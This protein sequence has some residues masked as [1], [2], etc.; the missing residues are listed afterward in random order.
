MAKKSYQRQSLFNQAI[1]GYRERHPEMNL[2]AVEQALAEFIHVS[3]ASVQKWRAGY[4]IREEYVPLI[5]NWAINH[6]G[7]S[8]AW[9]R[10]FL[11]S[12][13]YSD[14]DVEAVL[15]SESVIYSLVETCYQ[16]H[17]RL[18]GE[19]R[20]QAA[21][22]H[23]P[24]EGLLTLL[25]NFLTSEKP[26]LI[27]VAPSGMGKTD[28]ALW[29][30]HEKTFGDRPVL[31]CS[32]AIL[33]GELAFPELVTSILGTAPKY[34]ASSL[35][36]WPLLVILDGV[37]ESLDMFRLA[38]Q[39]DRALL[40]ASGLKVLLTFRPESFNL[41]RQTVSLSEHCY[42]SGLPLDF[43]SSW[44]SFPIHTL[45]LFDEKEVAMAYER[46]QKVYQLQTPFSEISPFLKEYLRHPLNL[47]LIAETWRG[48]PLPQ[49]IE[50]HRLVQKFLDN[51]YSHGRLSRIDLQ[52]LEQKV[53]A[54]MMLPGHW[55]NSV[56]LDWVLNSNEQLDVSHPLIRL[57][58][59]GILSASNGRLD[60]PIRFA[61][62][63]FY[64]YFSEGY[65]RK[66]REESPDLVTFYATLYDLPWFLYG[67][68]RRILT[69]ELDRM[70]YSG[71]NKVF[72]ATLANLPQP[73]L[74]YAIGEYCRIHPD[75]V[76]GFLRCLWRLTKS[77]FL[78]SQFW[79]KNLQKVLLV[80]A[81]SVQ[82]GPLLIEFLEEASSDSQEFG[83][84]QAKELWG[85]SPRLA[86]FVFKHL[87]RDLISWK[88]LP[89]FRLIPLWGQFLL[90]SFLDYGT[91]SEVLIFLERLLRAAARE[92]ERRRFVVLRRLVACWFSFWLNHS[93]VNIHLTGNLNRDLHFTSQQ[94]QAVKAI[95]SYIAW[96]TP[97]FAS[98]ETFSHLLTAL[99]SGSLI[100]NWI[101]IV[102]F[103]E[104]ALGH[105]E[106]TWEVLGRFLSLAAQPFPPH[107]ADSI[108]FSALE[109][110]R[111]A[112]AVFE[113]SNVWDL[114]EPVLIGMLESYPAWHE[115]HRKKRMSRP[116]NLRGAA[117]GIGPYVLACAALQRS[118][119]GKVWEVIVKNLR[120]GPVAFV[121]D[122]LQEM[123]FVGLDGN[124][125]RLALNLLE[126]V[127]YHPN[128]RVRKAL[129][130]LLGEIS[131]VAQFDLQAFLE[132]VNAPALTAM[133]C[134]SSS[135]RPPHTWLYY[136]L[137]AWFYPFIFRL[138][139]YRHLT[140]EV[141][142]CA[143]ESKTVCQWV[144]QSIKLILKAMAGADKDR[145]I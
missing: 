10:A 65:L 48:Q 33:D 55:C 67:P 40:N 116:R 77:S 29:L 12:C 70:G 140:L 137:A 54:M 46:Y 88:S 37:N 52:F 104:Q 132:R 115:E 129:I 2:G 20:L 15:Y 93:A 73:V 28:F 42:Y 22:L 111:H 74:V 91:R 11:R 103:V 105:P 121:L 131:L 96:D 92:N 56:P 80:V 6:A 123:H 53:L 25:K 87:T 64:E 68:L 136:R 50:E 95:I 134:Q 69:E 106:E 107:W 100:A 66:R 145:L 71:C 133:V 82:N 125:A 108:V 139:R 13:D 34:G 21:V 57:A 112:P 47:R 9:G 98:E 35:L 118:V 90:L 39:V 24:R 27:L 41:L 102:A 126:P 76:S 36:S 26:G 62:E 30:A 114:L 130:S 58:D 4:P 45:S 122:Y 79:Q 84:I 94:R 16:A 143:L 120:E 97:G 85:T 127:A 14:V 81:I 51:L 124:Q 141:F 89:N 113:A 49:Y 17:L 110:A 109:C 38:W 5:V 78:P 31:A 119:G 117:Q 7:M 60:E 83:I 99:E 135:N 75:K 63:R 61:H 1:Y 138:P 59:A 101:V 144:D 3:Q 86:R 23:Q 44:K 128:P 32:A 43:E 72:W 8:L 19:Q 18:W 142:F